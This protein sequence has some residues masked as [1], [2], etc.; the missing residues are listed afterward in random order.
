[1][2]IMT[3]TK[4]STRATNVGHTKTVDSQQHS[5][6]FYLYICLYALLYL[7]LILDSLTE[8]FHDHPA[9]MNKLE[10]SYT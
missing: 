6:H 8:L 4:I 3:H 10:T 5:T 9:Y 2:N 1:M 7:I